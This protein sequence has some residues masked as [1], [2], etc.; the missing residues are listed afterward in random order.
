[1]KV[2]FVIDEYRN[3]HAGTEGQLALLVR[4]L[5]ARGHEVRLAVF[6]S[7]EY[8]RSGRFPARVDVLDIKRMSNP[9][10]WRRLFRWGRECAAE[11][12][13]VAQIFFNDASIIGPWCLKSA[14]L[15]VIV[16]RRD[17][18]F[19]CTGPVTAGLRMA[20]PAVD[21]VIANCRAA[22]LAA[23]Q[24]EGIP[25]K[26]LHVVYNGIESGDTGGTDVG[27]GAARSHSAG[28]ETHAEP[29]QGRHPGRIGIVAN[30]RPIKRIAD[31]LA[32]LALI[33]DK[34]PGAELVV[35]GGGDPAS[36]QAEAAQLGI[37]KRVRFTGQL[38]DP[39]EW[40]RTFSIGV[41]CS[42][43]EGLSNAILEYMRAGVPVVA[44]HV[45]GNPELIVDGE[46]GALVPVGDPPAL[47]AALDRL[48]DDPAF[49]QRLGD[50]G[51]ERARRLFSVETMVDSH[52]SL[53][54]ALT[55]AACLIGSS[56]E[57]GVS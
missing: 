35:I 34:H 27:S 44:T 43:S 17:M 38:G 54:S 29:S 42:E 22:G 36:L 7:S 25:E 8:V 50:A 57:A 41:L 2:A 28:N 4:E 30:L 5:Q 3:P 53:Y 51:R 13:R 37:E 56:A 12:Y 52:L 1:M 55:G 40:V 11:G 46:T 18:G 47:A 20:A 48:L 33:A 23:C 15:K 32:A 6:R 26:K 31:A 10:G 45:G 24:R 19:W 14:G 16:S 21:A 49:A 39:G 9:L